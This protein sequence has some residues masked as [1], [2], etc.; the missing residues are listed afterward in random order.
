M[1]RFDAAVPGVIVPTVVTSTSPIS[2]PE[3]ADSFPIAFVPAGSAE[4]I[5]TAPVLQAV[6][7]VL[8]AASV[9][10]VD[11]PEG[12]ADERIST[13]SSH[14]ESTFIDCI[15]VPSSPIASVPV[16]VPLAAPS[17]Y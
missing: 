9:V 15:F 7:F 6:T 14:D 12:S 4:E 1:P 3:L 5:T 17:A 2:T 13:C 16:A 10:S 8:R 11:A